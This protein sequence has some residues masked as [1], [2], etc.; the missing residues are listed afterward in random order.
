MTMLKCPKCGSDQIDKGKIISAGAIT[1]QSGKQKHPFIKQNCTTYACV[2]CGFCETYVDTEY[3][4][5]MSK[6]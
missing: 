6:R 5:E 1:F 3:L 2:K 4:E